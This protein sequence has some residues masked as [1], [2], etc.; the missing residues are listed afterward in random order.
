MLLAY[1][2]AVQRFPFHYFD[3]VEW[4]CCTLGSGLNLSRELGLLSSPLRWEQVP[5][6]L[7]LSLPPSDC[8]SVGDECR[9]PRGW[10]T[11]GSFSLTALYDFWPRLWV[12]GFRSIVHFTCEIWVVI[13]FYHHPISW[14][15]ASSLFSSTVWFSF[16][17]AAL[18]PGLLLSFLLLCHWLW[19]ETIP[20]SCT[21]SLFSFFVWFP[22][23]SSQLDCEDTWIES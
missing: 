2:W 18:S 1:N 16:L 10:V 17:L 19:C 12:S 13:L 8:R 5:S 15:L 9:W 21:V 22:S 11:R 20:I 7:S 4:S 14:H 23:Q 3:V 6:S